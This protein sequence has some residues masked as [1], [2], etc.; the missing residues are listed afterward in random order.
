M[1]AEISPRELAEWRA[2][3]ELEPFGESR[4][5]LRAAQVSGTLA[6]IFR[7]QGSDVMPMQ[8]FIMRVGVTDE[9]RAVE[10]HQKQ[11]LQVIRHCFLNGLPIPPE[12]YSLEPSEEEP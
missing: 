10:A 1:L 7:K 9:D 2:F 12:S 8:D 4:A 6:N 5:D 11:R 3:A